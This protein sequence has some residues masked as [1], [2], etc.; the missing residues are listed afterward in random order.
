[1]KKLFSLVAVIALASIVLVACSPPTHQARIYSLDRV[2]INWNSVENPTGTAVTT[3]P[4]TEARLTFAGNQVSIRL[5]G[6]NLVANINPSEN[7]ASYNS[8]G[9]WHHHLYHTA[10]TTAGQRVNFVTAFPSLDIANPEVS[11][12][13][14]SAY[15][16][17]NLFLMQQE[18]NA[19][20]YRLQ[21]TIGGVTYNLFFTAED[22]DA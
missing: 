1:M 11:D 20:Q 16:R 13:T 17:A 22:V 3:S 10:P 5:N 7:H 8:T 9:G 21:I 4:I 14:S 19:Q 6:V 18:P 12:N 2:T 15:Q